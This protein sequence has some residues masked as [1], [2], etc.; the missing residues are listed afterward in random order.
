[1]YDL[2]FSPMQECLMLVLYLEMLG[3][4][5]LFVKSCSQ[6]KMWLH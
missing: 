2:I 1:M 6:R 4:R 3:E 5:M